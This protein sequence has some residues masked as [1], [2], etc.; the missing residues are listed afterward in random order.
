MLC[1]PV[2]IVYLSSLAYELL[3]YL[4]SWN[5]INVNLYSLKCPKS[6]DS[7]VFILTGGTGCLILVNIGSQRWARK[8]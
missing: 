5:D 3:V 4:P 2:F 7:E 6:D 1:G 8:E